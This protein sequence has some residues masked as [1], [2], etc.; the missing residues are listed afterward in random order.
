MVDVVFGDGEGFVY[1]NNG[2]LDYHL[3]VEGGKGVMP[4]LRVSERYMMM[5]GGC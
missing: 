1:D 2:G 3:P 5:S 4:G